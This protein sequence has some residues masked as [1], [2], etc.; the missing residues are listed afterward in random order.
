MRMQ[1]KYT[2][3][4][5]QGVNKLFRDRDKSNFGLRDVLQISTENVNKIFICG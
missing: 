1:I 5:I 3:Q 2:S 4:N